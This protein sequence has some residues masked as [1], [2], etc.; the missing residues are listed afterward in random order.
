MRSEYLLAATRLRTPLWQMKA[1]RSSRHGAMISACSSNVT[2]LSAEAPPSVLVSASTDLPPHNARGCPPLGR[3]DT[4]EV[5]KGTLDVPV[6][7]TVGV[8][9]ANAAIA[10]HPDVLIQVADIKYGMV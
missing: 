2:D 1:K 4:T 9:L 6:R 10:T 5:S 7:A 8:F 3:I